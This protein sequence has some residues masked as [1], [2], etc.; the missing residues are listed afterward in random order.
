MAASPFSSGSCFLEASSSS[1]PT[2][3]TRLAEKLEQKLEVEV[4]HHQGWSREQA[5][6]GDGRSCHARPECIHLYFHLTPDGEVIFIPR[7]ITCAWTSCGTEWNED[8]MG[9]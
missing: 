1:S 5:G 3:D 2:G 8:A 9:E 7:S 6:R 4:H